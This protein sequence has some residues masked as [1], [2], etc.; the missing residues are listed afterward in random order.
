MNK[1]T[2]Y[3]PPPGG[4]AWR[5]SKELPLLYLAWGERRYGKTPLP[6]ERVND[7]IY[8]TPRS[9]APM[10]HVNGELLE[11]TRH[12][13][14]ILAPGCVASY[15]DK[16]DGRCFIETWVWGPPPQFS[17][18]QPPVNS[19][20]LLLRLSPAQSR[21]L[22]AIHD[23]C[24]SEVQHPDAFTPAALAAL[25]L[26]LDL[27]L[28][29]GSAGRISSQVSGSQRM[30][31]ALRWLREHPDRHSPAKG[32]CDYLQVSPATLRRLFTTHL[33]HGPREEALRMRLAA[34]RKLIGEEGWSVKAAAYHL[35]YLHPN[36]LSRALSKR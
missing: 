30:A 7:W 33:G 13:C 26:R 23:S 21:E 36:D 35:G 25:R 3:H 4:A 5:G 11:L 17:A 2:L 8:V 31:L 19:G 28:A 12:H 10:V 22:S 20:F 1:D 9:G 32:L 6:P 16:P 14:L 24:R 27:V 29:R 34:A 15:Q 18:L